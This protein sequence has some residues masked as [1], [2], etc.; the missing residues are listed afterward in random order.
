MFRVLG[1]G[2]GVWGF[3][4]RFWCLGFYGYGLVFRVLG[5][6]FGVQGFRVRVLCLWF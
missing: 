1:L 4:V 3:G 2:F 6:G 5:L